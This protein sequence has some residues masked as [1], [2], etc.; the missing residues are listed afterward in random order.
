MSHQSNQSLRRFNQFV[1]LQA[2]GSAFLSLADWAYEKPSVSNQPQ[3][4]SVFEKE[5]AS[6]AANLNPSKVHKH[7]NGVCKT[8][9]RILNVPGEFNEDEV[10]QVL[11]IRIQLEHAFALINKMNWQKLDLNLLLADE[12][13]KLILRD[14]RNMSAAKTAIAQIMRNWSIPK[15]LSWVTN[16]NR[17]DDI[18]GRRRTI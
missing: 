14:R 2:D 7:L 4:T 8:L 6:L 1:E 18:V 10:V 13:I 12:R 5:L 3:E 11:S 17:T 16:D 15:S 9:E